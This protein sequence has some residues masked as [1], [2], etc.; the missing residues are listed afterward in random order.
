MDP[1]CLSEIPD[2]SFSVPDPVPQQRLSICIG[3]TIPGC[4]SRIWIFFRSGSLIQGSKSTGPGSA[5]LLLPWVRYSEFLFYSFSA[6]LFYMVVLILGFYFNKQ[7]DV[8]GPFRALSDSNPSKEW[9]VPTHHKKIKCKKMSEHNGFFW[10]KSHLFLMP[11][12]M[13]KRYK[14]LVSR[15]R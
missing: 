6:D 12:W 13:S 10:E 3:N 11:V 8:S 14:G 1:G 7:N 4:L 9:P 2:V 15:D 5:T